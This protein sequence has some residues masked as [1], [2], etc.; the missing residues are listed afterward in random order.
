MTEKLKSCP[1]CGSHDVEV[2]FGEDTG[3]VNDH[4]FIVICPDCGGAGCPSENEERATY[5]WNS[6]RRGPLLPSKFVGII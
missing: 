1:F 4:Q 2:Y 3:L 5:M 6:R